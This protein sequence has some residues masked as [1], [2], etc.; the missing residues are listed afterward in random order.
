MKITQYWKLRDRE[1]TEN[2]AETVEHVRWLVFDAIQRQMVSDVPIGTFL[3]GG[4]DSSI[5]TAICAGQE[6]KNG[7]G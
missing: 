3:S 5:I 7:K 2:F 1:H 6:K 4:L